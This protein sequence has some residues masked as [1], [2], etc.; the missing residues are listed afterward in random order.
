M[1]PPEQ[2][3][4]F[5]L[6]Q[7]NCRKT[8]DSGGDEPYLWILGFKVDADTI[9]P[10]VG[11]LIPSLG[12]KIFEGMPSFP[13][14]LGTGSVDAPADLPIPGALGTRAFRLRP[15]LLATG[16]WFAGLAGMIVLLWE[17]DAFSPTTAEAGYNEFK[18][19][20]GPAL[21]AELTNLLN[22]SYDTQLSQDAKGN[23]VST[24]G[25]GLPLPWRLSRLGDSGA[26]ANAVSAITENVKGQI[27]GSIH[28]ALK[29]AAGYDELIDPDDLLGVNAQVYLGDELSST[30]QDFSMDFNAGAQ[31]TALGHAIGSR[32]R[33]A[34]IEATVTEVT[35]TFDGQVGLFMRVCWFEAK[36]YF[37]SAFR[38]ATKTRYELRSFGPDQPAAVRWFL[39]GKPLAGTGSVTVHFEPADKYFGPP[40]DALAAKYPGGD[41]ALNFQETGS[42]LEISNQGGVGVFFGTVTALYSFPGDPSL[43]PVPDQPMDQLQKLSYQQVAD[44]GVFGVELTMDNTYRS[45]VAACKRVV[46]DID[47]KHIAANFGKA[48]IDPGDPPDQRVILDRVIL[49]ARVA[50]AVGLNQVRAPRQTNVALRQQAKESEIE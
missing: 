8:E 44:L 2:D 15:D 45:D 9:A 27:Y 11:S 43:F 30:V 32:I 19:V 29:S 12:V 42:V 41:G 20:F 49:D 31:Y 35:R 23:V 10:V 5:V 38:V 36:E 4:T 34:H 22:G 37:A 50:N 16:D 33:L 13:Y 24:P 18:K 25:S 48:F 26:R 47:R 39:D 1:R 14:L 3:V 7:L 46:Q 6:Y 17:Q 21:S 40:Q 28:D